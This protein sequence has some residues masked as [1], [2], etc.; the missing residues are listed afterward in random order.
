M[1]VTGLFSAL[2][3]TSCPHLSPNSLEYLNFTVEG[4]G[5]EEESGQEA[6]PDRQC[7]S[8]LA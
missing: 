1:S 3:I 4:R 6:L 2:L 7:H 5:K 8:N